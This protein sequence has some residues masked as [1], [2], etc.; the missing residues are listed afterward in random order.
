MIE[1]SFFFPIALDVFTL[2]FDI[3]LISKLK[4]ET[5]FKN[6]KEID[7]IIMAKINEDCNKDN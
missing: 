4:V 5:Y 2:L 3:V 6:C 1:M 7:M